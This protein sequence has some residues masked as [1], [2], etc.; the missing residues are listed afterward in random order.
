MFRKKINGISIFNCYRQVQLEC[1]FGIPESEEFN[2]GF[3]KEV[4]ELTQEQID[5]M[6]RSA[7]EDEDE[8]DIIPY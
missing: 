8:D 1:Q 7:K 5:E 3:I 2:E 4:E 6:I